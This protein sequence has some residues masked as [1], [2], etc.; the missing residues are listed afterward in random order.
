MIFY[1]QVRTPE[2]TI[3]V[4]FPFEVSVKTECRNHSRENRTIFRNV[5]VNWINRE[6]EIKITLGRNFDP[7]GGGHENVAVTGT[8]EHTRQDSMSNTRV[9]TPSRG[10]FLFSHWSAKYWQRCLLFSIK[11][12]FFTIAAIF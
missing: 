1:K 11:L 8:V 2:C 12:L 6:G 10:L 5:P 9:K 7:L 3:K 4:F